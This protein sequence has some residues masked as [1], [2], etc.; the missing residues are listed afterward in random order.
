MILTSVTLL[1]STW[2]NLIDFLFEEN[3]CFV[4]QLSH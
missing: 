3:D 2:G 1:I 4:L